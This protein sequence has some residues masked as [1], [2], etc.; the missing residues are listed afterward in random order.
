MTAKVK[1]NT[2][3]RYLGS[4]FEDYLK[5]KGTF[6]EVKALTQKR[7]EELQTQKSSDTSENIEVSPGRIYRFFQWLRHAIN[8]L[9][10]SSATKPPCFSWGM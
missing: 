5:E 7:W 4:K 1:A 9:I 3:N 10:K 6:E 8:Q 2:S